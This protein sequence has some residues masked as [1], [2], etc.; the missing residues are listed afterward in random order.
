MSQAEQ[1]RSTARGQDVMDE[2]LKSAEDSGIQSFKE[3]ETVKAT[4][5]LRSIWGGHDQSYKTIDGRQLS[6]ST[7]MLSAVLGSPF[8]DAPKQEQ[9]AFL[10]YCVAQQLDPLRR[11]VHFVKFGQMPAAYVTSWEVFLE[12][13]QRHP[14]FDG[15]EN[16]IIW[17]VD[18]NIELLGPCDY[19]QDKDHVIVGGWCTVFRKDQKHPRTVQVPLDEMMGKKRDGSPTRTWA[20]QLTT[21]SIKTPTCRA[22]RQSFPEQLQGLY[23]E[24]ETERFAADMAAEPEGLKSG[25]TVPPSDLDEL[26]QPDEDKIIGD[27]GDRLKAETGP[28]PDPNPFSSDDEEFSEALKTETEGEDGKS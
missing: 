25:D 4:V 28:E 23:G 16:G 12:R 11:Q 27:M 20:T 3:M 18:S 15:F 22:L 7:K 17:R 5:D 2:V 19:T 8:A 13:A 14:H 10:A 21:M 1:Q 9:A 6:Y 26:L 24:T